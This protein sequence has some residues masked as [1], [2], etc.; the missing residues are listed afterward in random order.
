[1]DEE[2]LLMP[3]E[4]S[5]TVQCKEHIKIYLKWIISQGLENVSRRSIYQAVDNTA[6]FEQRYQGIKNEEKEE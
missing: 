4:Y 3:S 6:D 5:F 2:Y 1:M